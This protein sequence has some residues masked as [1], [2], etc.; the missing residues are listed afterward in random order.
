MALRIISYL[1]AFVFG[2]DVIVFPNIL[3]DESGIFKSV[4]PILYYMKRVDDDE[5]FYFRI[6]LGLSILGVSISLIFFWEY[7]VYGFETLFSI[8]SS[9]NDWGKNKMEEIHSGSNQISILNKHKEY[10]NMI[11]DV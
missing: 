11:D 1:I 8:F 9:I 3:T 2:Y 7:T 10:M 6:L 4:F 5:T